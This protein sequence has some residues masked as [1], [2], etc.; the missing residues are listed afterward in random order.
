M[1]KKHARLPS[2]ELYITTKLY[3]HGL[4]ILIRSLR[5][6][7]VLMRPHTHRDAHLKL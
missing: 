5:Q 7:I 4:Q 2:V 3:F 6:H 1:E